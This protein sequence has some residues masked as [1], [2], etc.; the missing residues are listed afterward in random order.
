MDNKQKF[1]EQHLTLN[2]ESQ[3]L[4]EK[5]NIGSLGISTMTFIVK[6]STEVN[7][8]NLNMQFKS[9]SFPL[10]C[11]KKTKQHHE[12]ETTKRGKHKLSFYN[13][14]TINF[15]ENTKKSIKIFSNGR[16]Q[17]TGITSYNDAIATTDVIIKVIELSGAS[18]KDDAHALSYDPVLVNSNFSFLC[19]LNILKLKNI[20]KTNK[21]F[22]VE[23]KPD[24]YP[25]LKIKYKESSS[26]FLFTTGNVVITGIKSIPFVLTTFSAIVDIVC[27]HLSAIKIVQTESKKDKKEILYKNGYKITEYNACIM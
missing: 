4:K 8:S 21:D 18:Y 26:I 20:L 23:Y 13:Q 16:L 17:M 25:G 1:V 27:F 7:I 11:L 22:K 5:H 19:S 12:Y 10:C 9:T 14:V 24:V 2:E 6:L 3:K 15:V